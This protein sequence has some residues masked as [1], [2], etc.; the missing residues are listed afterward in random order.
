MHIQEPYQCCMEF[1]L[2]ARAPFNILVSSTHF[3]VDA[4]KETGHVQLNCM[5]TKSI[6]VF[7]NIHLYSY[8]QQDQINYH[9]N[10]FVGFNRFTSI[11][12]VM[13]FLLVRVCVCMQKN[14]IH[15]PMTQHQLNQN[16]RQ[17]T[18]RQH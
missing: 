18:T 4:K 5:L 2:D 11:F 3:L 17:H 14:G 15:E 8:S 12:N 13:A 6:F 7:Q 1:I 9:L 10:Y 16:T